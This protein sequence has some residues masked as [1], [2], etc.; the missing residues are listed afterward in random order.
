MNAAA[1]Q[2]LIFFGMKK[3]GKAVAEVTLEDCNSEIL[4]P[5]AFLDSIAAAELIIRGHILEV[6]AETEME[7]LR[8]IELIHGYSSQIAFPRLPEVLRKSTGYIIKNLDIYRQTAHLRTRLFGEEVNSQELVEF[9]L[10]FAFEAIEPMMIE[11]WEQIILLHLPEY[12]FEID[13]HIET[14]LI[15]YQIDVSDHDSMGM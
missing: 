6:E 15:R 7:D 2:N 9:T 10:R 1:A 8:A 12:D 14:Y 11:F 4:I 5:L 13:Q 3:L